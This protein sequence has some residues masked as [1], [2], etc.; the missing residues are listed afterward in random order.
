ME[1]SRK[2][3]HA[4]ELL[5]SADSV[6]LADC[7]G[8]VSNS[9]TGWL[10]LTSP[11]VTS[12]HLLFASR[13]NCCFALSKFSSVLGPYPL[14]LGSWSLPTHLNGAR[15]ICAAG[16]IGACRAAAICSEPAGSWSKNL[17]TLPP[18]PPGE[19]RED[20]VLLELPL[21]WFID[22]RRLS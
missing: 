3:S 4:L 15:H 8:M 1:G 17:S 9:L 16:G 7:D 19:C 5:V 12:G 11:A 14:L 21:S 10:V 6:L 20:R 22:E 18:V 13:F 2:Q